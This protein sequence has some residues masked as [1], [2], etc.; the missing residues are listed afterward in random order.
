MLA[1]IVVAAVVVI[2]LLVN[3]GTIKLSQ[4][5]LRQLPLSRIQQMLLILLKIQS[6]LKAHIFSMKVRSLTISALL[7]GKLSIRIQT[8]H[9]LFRMSMPIL[10]F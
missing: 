8:Q 4:K 5:E 10:I 7:K 3:N 9:L 6:P 1:V 2:A